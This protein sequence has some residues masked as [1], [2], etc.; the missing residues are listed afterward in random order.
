MV[1]DSTTQALRLKFFLEEKGFSVETASDG[2]KGLD[3]VRRTRPTLIISDVEMPRMNGFSLCA[4]IKQDEELKNTLVMMLTSLS[5][6]QDII[7]GLNA[8]A[9]CY[10]TKPYNEDFLLEKLDSLLFQLHGINGNE[11]KLEFSVWFKG[12]TR[13]VSAAPGRMLSLLLSVY[14]DAV[15]MGYE[16]Q[17]TKEELNDLNENLEQQVIERTT[18]LE[19]Q[20]AERSA[21][22]M[23]LLE[24]LDNTRQFALGV[25]QALFSVLMT[26]DPLT[27]RHQRRVARI[28][29]AL[30]E[31]MGL[32]KGAP[33]GLEPG[34]PCP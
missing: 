17:K 25:T 18:E 10:V 23:D 31:E 3:I 9:D 2:E 15:L 6:P 16:L 34:S 30:G 21:A 24:H 26:Q 1:E 22:E 12:K 8:G 13:T 33:G 19:V 20:I 11:E 28:A 5:D 14:E 4:A 7:R 27:A 29:K 32:E